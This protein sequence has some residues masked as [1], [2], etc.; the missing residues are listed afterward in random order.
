MGLEFNVA[1]IEAQTECEAL[2]ARLQNET[3]QRTALEAQLAQT[4]KLLEEEKDASNAIQQYL[5]SAERECSDVGDRLRQARE[6]YAELLAEAARRVQAVE[7]KYVGEQVNYRAELLG[8]EKELEE[9]LEEVES[10]L[11]RKEEELQLEKQKRENIE[12]EMQAALAQA[13]GQVGTDRLRNYAQLW[14]RRTR[15]WKQQNLSEQDS[16]HFWRG[17]STDI[18]FFGYR[19]G[20][21]RSLQIQGSTK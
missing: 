17:M 6:D 18:T 5:E 8:R 21:S 12:V 20:C 16:W 2:R 9:D 7:W 15:P 10:T 4:K 14:R 13:G 1:L 3:A 11:E 19:F